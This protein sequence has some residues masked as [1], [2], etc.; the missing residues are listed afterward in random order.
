MEAYTGV[1]GYL[2]SPIFCIPIHSIF[3]TPIWNILRIYGT[4]K[5]TPEEILYPIAVRK[6]LNERRS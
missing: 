3:H 2:A 1:I 6:K 4:P 5:Y